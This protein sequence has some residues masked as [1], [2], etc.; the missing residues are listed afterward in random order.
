M[1]LTLTSAWNPCTSSPLFEFTATCVSSLEETGRL[2]I[3]VAHG[4]GPFKQFWHRHNIYASKSLSWCQQDQR[5]ELVPLFV[6][7]L[8]V[9]FTLQVRASLVKIVRWDDGEAVFLSQVQ[10]ESNLSLRRTKH[11]SCTRATDKKQSKCNRN[12]YTQKTQRAKSWRPS[13]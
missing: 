12:M 11:K 10:Q 13:Q 2:P 4:Q 1:G 6:D 5:R 3:K 8:V 7:T 9:N